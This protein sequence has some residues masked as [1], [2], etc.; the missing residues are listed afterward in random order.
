MVH[1]SRSTVIPFVVE[2][3]FVHLT[4]TEVVYPEE[5]VFIALTFQGSELSICT[6]EEEGRVEAPSVHD[7][8]G[9]MVHPNIG[10]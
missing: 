2:P 4:H 7:P 9:W 1:P 6:F 10:H 5:I 3:V 8:L